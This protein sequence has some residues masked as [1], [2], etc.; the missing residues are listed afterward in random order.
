MVVKKL[1]RF[2]N[3]GVISKPDDPDDLRS[4][5]RIKK[6]LASMRDEDQTQQ[7]DDQTEV[8]RLH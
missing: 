2:F 3:T 8:S 6:S 4:A 1:S 5:Q 7:N